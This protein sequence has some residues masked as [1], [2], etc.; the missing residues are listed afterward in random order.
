MDSA[1]ERMQ[2]RARA[3]KTRAQVRAWQYR[4]RDLAAGVW[5][6]LRRVLTNARAAYVLTEEDASR[7]VA[8]GFQPESCGLELSPEKTIVFLNA[9]RAAQLDAPRPI[10]VSL[11]AEFLAARAIALVAFDEGGS[12]STPR[13]AREP[14]ST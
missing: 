7:L 4:Q 5:F 6:R 8:E 1:L 10:P 2:A 14:L 9:D 12:R 3:V 13:S 11:G